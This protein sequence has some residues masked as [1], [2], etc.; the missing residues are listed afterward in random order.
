VAA[1]GVWLTAS[2]AHAG[3]WLDG[4]DKHGCPPTAYSPLHV[5][6]PGLYRIYAACHLPAVPLYAADRYPGVPNNVDVTHFRCPAV[7]PAALPSPYLAGP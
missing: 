5:L 7:P 6:T 1:V 2:A 4:H 3:P